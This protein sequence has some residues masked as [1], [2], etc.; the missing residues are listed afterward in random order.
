MLPPTPRSRKYSLP[1]RVS[2]KVLH[3]FLISAFA[4][5]APPL[6]SSFIES[7]QQW[8]LKGTYYEAPHYVIVSVT[9]TFP[10][11]SVRIFP[12][13]PSFLALSI[14]SYRQQDCLRDGQ[15]SACC[16]GH[17]RLLF[18]STF[19]TAWGPLSFPTK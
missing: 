8:Q 17:K 7:P 9:V 15:I 3:D 12:P 13:T 16:Q 6:S 10:H 19:R 18:S 1:L 11:S 2:F 14:Y 4:L 5:H